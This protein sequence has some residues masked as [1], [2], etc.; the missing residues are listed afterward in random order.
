MEILYIT[1]AK[2]LLEVADLVLD[3]LNTIK[4]LK[5]V[6]WDCDSIIENNL[7]GFKSQKSLKPTKI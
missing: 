4:S 2:E 1:E 3:S 6:K 5:R 7:C